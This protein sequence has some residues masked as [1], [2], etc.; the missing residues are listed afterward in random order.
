M[1]QYFTLVSLAEWAMGHHFTIVGIMRYDHKVIPKEKKLLRG[2]E[3]HSVRIPRQKGHG[4][5]FLYQH[6]GVREEIYCCSYHHAW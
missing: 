2:R 4:D 3:V 1:D 6:E 5:A